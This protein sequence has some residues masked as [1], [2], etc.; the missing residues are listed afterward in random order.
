MDV[1]NCKITHYPV[2]VLAKKAEPVELI[3]DNI[4]QLAEKMIEIM[5]DCGGI[6][7]AAPQAGIALRM[8]VIS[9]DSSKENATVY[10]NPAIE[11]NGK[12]ESSE[13][14][15]LSLPGVHTKVPRYSKC[16]ITATDL[17]GNE[18]TQNADGLLARAVQHEY[19][20]IEGVLIADRMSSV[21]KI[22]NRKKLKDLRKTHE[23]NL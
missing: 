22:A 1:Q 4:K 19:D 23:K 11:P 14:G 15:C 9:L 2:P 18:F 13:E 10:I 17:N 8:F 7:L 5:Q 3:D 21:A 6:G 20:H 16:K 12:I